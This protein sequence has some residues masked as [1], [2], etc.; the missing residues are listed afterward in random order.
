MPNL[1]LIFI[2]FALALAHYIGLHRSI[3][4]KS[5]LQNLRSFSGGFSVAYVFL[6]VF[7]E[8]YRLNTQSSVDTLVLTVIGF[9]LFHVLLKFIFK[10][11]SSKKRT[12]LLDEIHTGTAAL[13]SFLLSFSLVEISKQNVSTSMILVVLV[14]LHTTLSELSHKELTHHA[15]APWKTPVLITAT[16]LGGL[17]PIINLATTSLTAIL[18]AFAAGAIMYITIRE[19]VPEGKEGRPGLFLM[20]VFLLIIAKLYI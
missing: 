18:Y 2:P 9:A 12:L 13:Y 14:I 1:P 8:I 7:P 6:I 19:E 17:F 16:L 15:K 20:G 10:Q 11:R 4:D 3:K 5:I